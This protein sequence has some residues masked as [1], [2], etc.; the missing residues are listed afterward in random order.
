MS[1]RRD[2]SIG[3]ETEHYALDVSTGIPGKYDVITTFDVVHHA[4]DPQGLL[5]AIRA[6]LNDNGVYVGLDINAS[7]RL[8]EIKGPLATFFSCSQR[9]VLHDSFAGAGCR[10]W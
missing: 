2:R 9:V 5:R 4:V 8:E 6:A 3:R 7:H 10:S 1:E